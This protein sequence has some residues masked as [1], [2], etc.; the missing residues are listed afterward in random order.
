MSERKTAEIKFR[1]TPS[2]KAGAQAAADA[3]DQSLTEFIESVVWAHHNQ[4]AAAAED[5]HAQ[6]VRRFDDPE[7]PVVDRLAEQLAEAR[8]PHP[9]SEQ[10]LALTT[11]LKRD[12]TIESCNGNCRPWEFCRCKAEA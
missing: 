6:A 10:A 2:F 8:K 12:I 1:C 7:T 3:A 4:L 11:A 9:E 5:F